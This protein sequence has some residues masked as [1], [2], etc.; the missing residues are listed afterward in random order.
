MNSPDFDL[1]APFDTSATP[2]WWL[3]P[4]RIF[5]GRNFHERIALRVRKGLIVEF[6]DPIGGLR[7][8][9]PVWHINGTVTPG[10]FDIQ[11]NGGGGRM[12][13]NSPTTTTL[14]H[15]GK[16]LHRRGTT[17][18]LPTF[19][20]DTP[21]RMVL[22]AEA[23]KDGY[24][25]NGV[26]GVH[27]EGPHISIER[28]GAHKAG[29]IHELGEPTYTLLQDLRNH[30]IPVLLTLAPEAQPSGCI[31]RLCEMGVRV[32][33]GHSAADSRQVEDALRE[34]AC[35]F[36]HLY[37]GMTPMSSREP[38]VVGAALDSEAWCGVI[39]DGYHVADAMLRI[40]IRSRPLQDRMVLV[41][42]AMATLGGPPQFELYGEE[43]RVLNGKLV[44]QAG[45]LAGAH[46]DLATS[47]Q[48]M[49]NEVGIDPLQV[50]RMAT[51]NPAELMG[52]SPVVGSICLGERSPLLVFDS[53]WKHVATL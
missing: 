24:G 48:R 18:W 2:E 36:T 40:A 16:M 31:R 46:I 33:I 3:L 15:I 50:F 28:R 21:E 17:S 22:A 42:D 30:G 1:H 25:Q 11:V 52:L 26:T 12:F 19:V 6:R 41:S 9:L 20:T 32:S 51:T 10:L 5:D 53:L 27:F 7:T 47:V 37:N 4:A 23:I 44:N 14:T 8:D 39:G 45:S 34:G 38:G 49:I 29:L 35:S 43:I 13:N